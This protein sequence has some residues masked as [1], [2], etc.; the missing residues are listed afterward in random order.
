MGG[1]TLSSS[2]TRLEALDIQSSAYGVTIP[3]VYGVNRVAGNLLWYGAFKQI[4]KT[5]S[6]GGKGGVKQTNTTY[7]YSASVIMGIAE[8]Q[9]AGVSRVWKGKQL[10]T[11][12]IAP[13]NLITTTQTYAVPGGGGS[14][15]VSNAAFFSSNVSVT[16]V[17][18]TLD[19]QLF[20]SE[21]VD[22][23]R[24]G[25]VYSFPSGSRC[26]GLTVTITYSYA[27]TG[28]AQ[29]ALAALGLSFASGALGQ[30]AWSYMTTNFPGQALGY[31]GLCYV[32]AQ[33]YSL[34][35]SAQ[36][37]N[38]TF[39]V[40]G[41]QAF[42]ISSSIPD[43]NPA[44]V[45]WDVLV[46]G[47]Y[48]AAFPA[49]MLGSVGQWGNYC[50]AA[51]LLMSPCIETQ[52]QAGEFITSMGKLTNTAPVWSGNRLKMIPYGDT[53]ITA[54]GVTYTP[55][56]TPVYDLTDDDFLNDNA[57]PIVVERL[58]QA[59]A[60]NHVRVEFLDRGSYDSTNKVW[61]GG[62]NVTI[63]EAKD[64]A[65]IDAFG[66]RSAEIVQAHW[67]CDAA[68]A[69]AVAQLILQ[70]TLYV[71]N[72]Y[73]FTCPW[74][75][76]LL[77]PMDLVTLTDAGLGFNKLAVRITAVTESNE[78]DLTFTA[79]DFPLGIA[80]GAL[81]SNPVNAGYQHNYNASPGSVNSPVI[82]EAPPSL[83]VTGLEVYIAAAGSGQYWGGA[84]VWVSLDGTNYKQI[85]T[86]NG[87]SRY[88]A[89]STAAGST[90]GVQ[91][92]SGTLTSGSAADSAAYSTLCYV[93]G[94]TPEYLAYQTATL[95]GAGA[96]T[97]GG[98]TR[99][100]YGTSSSVHT[101]GD[102]FV[103]VDS[104]IVKSGALD[105]S[106]IGTNLHVKLT[107]FNIYGSAEES[108]ASVTDY[109]YQI[110]GAIVKLP[111][112]APT[113][114][115]SSTEQFGIRLSCVKSVD[116]DV[117]SYEYRQGATWASGTVLTSQ[118]GT[119]YLWQVTAV[120]TF[121]FWVAAID[122]FGNYSAP[123][124][125]VVTV[126]AGTISGLASNILGTD[127][128]LSWAPVAGAFANQTSEVRYGATFATATV[129]G[130]FASAYRETVLFSGSRIYWVVPIDVR[131]NYGTP[132][133][134][135][136]SIAPPGAINS[137]RADIVDNDVLLY[138][139]APSSGTLPIDHYEVRKGSTFAGGQVIGS[140]G[141]STFTGVF[142]QVAGTYTYWIVAWDTAGNMGTPAS[143][144]AMVLQPPDYI[145]RTNY[146][147]GLG[148]TTPSGV[149]SATLSNLYAEQ[150]ALVG[151]VDPTQTW[152]THF[153][154]HSWTSPAD[155]ISAGYAIYAEPSVSSGTYTEVFDYGTVLQ[156]TTVTITPNVTAIAGAEVLSCQIYTSTDNITY[157]AVAAGFSA[158]CSNFRYI[159]YVITVTGTPGANLVQITQINV[160]LSI[161]QR[162]DSGQST[163]V[164][165][166]VTV[167]F[168][169]PFIEADTPVIQ[170]NGLD[171]HGKPFFAA[172]IYAGLPNPTSFV[173]RIFDSTGTEVSGVNF[174]WT[175][176]GY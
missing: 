88:G 114:F 142:E 121:T 95:T 105:L 13:T 28:G 123:V 115:T 41:A 109:V 20:F 70:R 44:I 69:Q 145:L 2:E 81:F 160:K 80:H 130:Q 58:P 120:G 78:G 72:T 124:S 158:L 23:S 68:I 1:Q 98:L 76:A 35:S 143:Q 118:G 155:Q 85:G 86:L 75:K 50:L 172:V 63:A 161:K 106:M 12:G 131:G 94:A 89:L 104:G 40:Q 51:G 74:T 125:T 57:D 169:Y 3:L 48:G 116:P 83:T 156:A 33:D 4:P 154:S 135:T 59:D 73:T 141:N 16:W 126:A 45:A 29:T 22:Y 170:P 25:G 157:T 176:R 65:N 53:A 171:S 136:V 62:Y 138:W 117:I 52:M 132:S 102:A 49:A 175:A 55:N 11:G 7:T 93:G 134:I 144:V 96:Y 39:E 173:V 113:V 82:F 32:Y 103:R 38:H 19:Q 152:A 122:A 100:G 84:N 79:E 61:T 90:V 9:I 137:Q 87:P 153:T 159:K 128:V 164:I 146:N 174:S 21:G 14:V 151:P 129:V 163:S 111:P 110:T 127:L 31:N 97:L 101:A 26:A 37:D 43:A 60:Y 77:E 165:G 17:S 67:I 150:G 112:I 46:N 56:V 167:N 24:V 108:L 18:G 91:N 5:T 34:G 140:N 15:S 66:L 166:G 36:V 107:S 42:S 27:T 92:M 149:L 10:Y 139:S 148:I 168:G 99:A 47:R 6:S 71:R 133:Q 54:N 147:S 162:T 8:G 30:A 64:S 119:S